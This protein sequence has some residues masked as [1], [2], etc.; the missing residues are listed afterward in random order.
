MKTIKLNQ[1]KSLPRHFMVSE[2]DAHLYDTRKI[3]WHKGEPLRKDYSKHFRDINTVAELK[4]TLRAGA[5]VWPGGYPL[6]FITS[7]NAALSWESVLENLN[8]IF[9][10]IKTKDRGG[11][12][13]VACDVNWEDTD[14]YCEHSGKPIESA[15]GEKED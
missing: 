3:D 14:L 11:W 13:V 15:Y 8:Q 2:C 10:A 12:Q 5:H 9:W 1:I 7:D 4:A 6:Y